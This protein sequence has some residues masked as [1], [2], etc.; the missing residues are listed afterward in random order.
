MN[1]G[2]RNM[3]VALALIVLVLLASWFAYGAGRV[4]GAS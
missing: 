1:R 4:A 2:S 3:L